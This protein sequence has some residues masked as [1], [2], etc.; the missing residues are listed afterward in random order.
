MQW[1]VRKYR[2]A[3]FLLSLKYRDSKYSTDKKESSKMWIKK[4]G[5]Y[6][7]ENFIKD[8][9]T[10]VH[11]LAKQGSLLPQKIRLIHLD[12]IVQTT[13]RFVNRRVPRL[14]K[15][16]EG[17]SQQFRNPFGSS[18][19]LRRV[20]PIFAVSAEIGREFSVRGEQ[21][22]WRDEDPTARASFVPRQQEVIYPETR[23]IGVSV[24]RQRPLPLSFPLASL[25]PRL[26]A[27]ARRISQGTGLPTGSTI[28]PLVQRSR[29][30]WSVHGQLPAINWI[31][32]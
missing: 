32:V 26:F 22:S 20:N 14:G 28:D 8:Y 17:G 12:P 4:F 5:K 29:V 31:E 24:P 23:W 18:F 7:K 10:I 25:D 15:V 9:A 19:L 21:E 27:V 2:K 13:F 6:I 30:T 3:P 11:P 1:N 16:L